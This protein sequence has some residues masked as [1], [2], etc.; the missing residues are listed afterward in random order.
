MKKYLFISFALLALVACTKPESTSRTQAPLRVRT[1]VVNPQGA[2]TVSRYVG[3]IEPAR[4]TPLSMQATGRVVT[5]N[6]K[7][8]Q[9]V[10]AGQTILTIDDTQ[11]KNALESARASL[12]HAQ[13][14]HDRVRKVYDKGVVSAQKMVEIESQL[15]QAQSFFDAAQQQL[16]ECT[17]KAPCGGIVNDLKLEVGQTVL[18]GTRLC[19]LL[20]ISGFSV[21]FTVPETEIG[22]LKGVSGKMKGEVECA[23]VDTVLPIVITETGVTANPVTHTYEVEARISG[24]ADIL[25]TGMVGVV[26]IQ[27]SIGNRQIVNDIVIPARCVLLKQDGH[28]VWVV[29]NGTAVRRY[30]TTEG[31]HADGVRVTSGLSEGDSLI[32]DGYQKLYN[33]C[34]VECTL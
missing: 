4:E 27:S 10:A 14:A 11:A 16:A 13:D 15:A 32:I 22:K 2:Q 7:N 3:T 29:E 26:K 12:R 5:V 8:G 24:G 31:F 23:A 34:A 18:P 19:S 6:V 30:I 33:G 1:M 20:D 9:R 28:T 25:M 21:R 17:L